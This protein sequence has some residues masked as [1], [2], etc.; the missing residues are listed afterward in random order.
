M[1]LTVVLATVAVLLIVSP[2]SLVLHGTALGRNLV[3]GA[4]DS[5]LAS[6]R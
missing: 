3:Y 1:A 6:A 5:P 4:L 2:L